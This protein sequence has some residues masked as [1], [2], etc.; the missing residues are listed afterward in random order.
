M[1]LILSYA[2]PPRCSQ[3]TDITK[4]L[5]TQSRHFYTIKFPSAT[6]LQPMAI[7]DPAETKHKRWK[8]NITFL[9]FQQKA[10]LKANKQMK[11]KTKWDHKHP[12]TWNHFW[13]LFYNEK[14]DKA[15]LKGIHKTKRNLYNTLNLIIYLLGIFFVCVTLCLPQHMNGYQRTIFRSS[16]SPFTM[17]V[18]VFKLEPS[19]LASNAFTQQTTRSLLSISIVKGVKILSI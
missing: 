13:L 19:D 2:P 17:W 10:N 9:F 8:I 12:L 14:T 1:F 16:L 5:T 6:S 4:A 18:P 7:K 3:T 11:N 15:K